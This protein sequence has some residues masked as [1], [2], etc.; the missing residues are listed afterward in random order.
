V[1][2]VAGSGAYIYLATGANTTGSEYGISVSPNEVYLLAGNGTAGFST[3]GTSATAAGQEIDASAVAFDPSGN[4]LLSNVDNASVDVIAIANSTAY[5]YTMTAGDIY[6]VVEQ[7]GAVAPEVNMPS[8][9]PFDFPVSS[10]ATD[11]QGDILIGLGSDGNGIALVDEQSAASVEYGKSL[12]PQTATFIAGYGGTCAHTCS[13]TSGI[14]AAAATTYVYDPGIA[15]DASGNVVFSTFSSSSL[16]TSD[17]V[18]VLPAMPGVAAGTSAPFGLYGQAASVAAGDLY[19]VAGK[20]GSVYPESANGVAAS[21]AVLDGPASVCLDPQ[22]NVIVGDNASASLLVVAESANAAWNV[23]GWTKGDVYTLS[24]G[25]GAVRTSLGNASGY[26]LQPVETVACD[27]SGDVYAATYSVNSGASFL[28][29]VNNGPHAPPVVTAVSPASG[30]AAG[31]TNVTITGTNLTGATGVSF[32]ATAATNVVVNGAGTQVTATSPTGTGTVDVTVTTAAGG[33]SATSAADDFTYI[34]APVVSSISPAS[35]PAAGGTNVTITGTN[36]TGATAVDFGTGN[37][38]TNVVVNGAGTQVTATSPTGTGTPDVQVTTPGG[39]SATSAND[40]FTYIPAPGASSISPA[41]GPAAGGTSV[42]ITG[43]NLTG[44]SAVDFGAGNAATTFSVNG[45]GTSITATSPTGTG[46]VSVT[47]TTPGGTV[48]AGQF[49]YIP[50]PTASSISPTAGGL[51]G[52]TTVTINGSNLTGAVVD[53]GTGN[54]ATNVQVNGAGTQVTATSPAGTGTVS[55]TVTTPGGGPVTAGQFTYTANPTVSSI[56]PTAGPVTGGTSVTITGS[57]LTGASAVDFGTGNAATNVQVN[58]AGTQVTATSPAGTAGTVDV[59]V[60]TAAGTS[61]TSPADQFTYGVVL[62]TVTNASTSAPVAGAVVSMCKLASTA[63]V[64]YATTGADGRYGIATSSTLL[65]GSYYM[66]ASPPTG[67]G[68]YPQDQGPVTVTTT[69]MATVNFAL[70]ATQLPAS[71]VTITYTSPVTGAASPAGT[72][73]QY[74]EPV[75]NWHQSYT[76]SGANACAGGTGTVTVTAFNYKTGEVETVTLP[77]V[78]A[79]IVSPSGTYSMTIPALYPLHGPATVNVDIACPSGP[80]QDSSFNVRIDPSG[81]VVDQYGDPIDGATVTLLSS[82]NAGGPFTAVPNGDSAVMTPS[83][84]PETTPAD[85]TFGWDVVPGYYEVQASRAGCSSATSAVYQ[86]PPPALGIQLV[87]TCNSTAIPLGGPT[88]G[89]TTVTLLGSG[90]TGALAVAFG[91][92]AAPSFV[93][94][95]PAGTEI[96]AVTP[97]EPAGP[98]YVYVV[99]SDGTV[100]QLPGFQFTFVPVPTVT[101]VCSPTG[102]NCASPASGPLSGTPATSVTITGTGFDSNGGLAGSVAVDFGNNPATSV[103]VNSDTSITATSPAGAAAGPVDVT[104]GTS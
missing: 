10:L 73:T 50:A 24:G 65:P 38:A 31:G 78:P 100:E 90:F 45:A 57:N 7:S 104:V 59:T 91:T 21:A 102:P 42:T 47:V 6:S 53:F 55:V 71:G 32:G 48:T 8:G 28:D 62:G 75:V 9:T 2:R 4:L 41:S 86:V 88:T 35:G 15:V 49:T 54:A 58:G 43:T 70:S 72:D 67:S 26:Q 61:G 92:Q 34:P 69:G 40:K 20:P 85:G 87:L 46:T 60:T 52:G 98:V 56:S 16:S 13:L 63:C 14:S 37:A 39:Q 44:A 51:S 76:L 74:G 79:F 68:L 97:A 77:P 23:T 1:D 83:T 101:G 80:A 19:L 12:T 18:W 82:A 29:Q 17:T 64:P 99:L 66:M 81:T 89:G 36:L 33:Q 5:K 94:G 30:P 95:N 3:Y 25:P 84:N 22:G 11:P 103:T 96:T 27:T 93:V